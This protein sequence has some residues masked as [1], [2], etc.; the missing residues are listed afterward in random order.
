MR[1]GI[2]HELKCPCKRTRKH[3]HANMR[4]HTR[5]QRVRTHAHARNRAHNAYAEACGAGAV[6]AALGAP[7][8]C[9]VVRRREDAGRPRLC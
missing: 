5:A 6:P 4:M 2:A 8:P 9:A 3:A 7:S 1:C